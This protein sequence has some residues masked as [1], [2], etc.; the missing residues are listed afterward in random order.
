M[1][2]VELQ[3]FAESPDKP[4]VSLSI[5]SALEQQFVINFG[6]NCDSVV[7]R[8]SCGGRLGRPCVFEFYGEGLLCA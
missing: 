7:T 2:P 5:R 3:R 8:I 4:S 1:H 6:A